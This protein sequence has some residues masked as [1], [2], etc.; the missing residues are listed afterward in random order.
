MTVGL[1]PW[2]Y[3]SL[4]ASNPASNSSKSQQSI[5]QCS[6]RGKTCSVASAIT[7]SAPSEPM[8]RLFKGCPNRD[9]GADT[10]STISPSA[11]ATLIPR[12]WSPIA[13]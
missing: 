6:G 13:P 12:T 8:N 4:I 9:W 7:P 2:A 10:V 11:S 5:S 3:I 1:S